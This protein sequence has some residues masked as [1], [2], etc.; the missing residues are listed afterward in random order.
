MAFVRAV[1]LAAGQGKRMKSSKPKVLHEVLGKPILQRVLDAIALAFGSDLEMVHVVVGHSAEQTRAFLDSVIDKIAGRSC[2]GSALPLTT[3]MQEPQLGTGHAVMQ[4]AEGLRDFKGTL[5][6]TVGDAPVM[7]A[8]TLKALL[9]KHRASLSAITALTAH[10]DEPQG[11]GRMVRDGKGQIQGIVEDKDATDLQKQIKEVNTGI[12]C[13]EWPLMAEG[14]S[15]LSCDNRQKE[16]YLT[17]LVAWAYGKG[18]KTESLVLADYREVVGINSRLELAEAARHLRDIVATR[19][20]LE[21]GVTILDPHTTWIA[22]EVKIGQETI[23]LP[24]CILQGDIE[25]GEH[26][27]IGP[28]STIKGRCV[29]GAKSSVVSSFVN[30]SLVGE[31][32]KIGPFAHLREGNQVGDGSKVGNFVE[33]KK[34]TLGTRTNVGHLSYV[35]DASLG[36]HVNI[37]AGT[38]TANYDHLTKIKA[39][40]TVADGASTGSNSVLV[41]PVSIE[42]E[43]VVAAGSVV[44][45]TVPAGALAVARAR[46]E[47]KEGWSRRKKQALVT[48]PVPAGLQD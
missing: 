23:I 13:L 2:F 28:N 18:L 25:I 5:L 47:N 8:E 46:Q 30:D 33:L 41:A 36:N 17:D 29:I 37:G 9:E 22:P 42:E 48:S 34:T 40:T 4:A 1:V 31:G 20:S 15:G 3:H 7:Q 45:K 27:T 11:Y 19:L 32:V 38:I 21:S 39:R 44:T 14:L 24:G 26:V 12:Y 10:L 43:A 16:Y 35:G 6:V